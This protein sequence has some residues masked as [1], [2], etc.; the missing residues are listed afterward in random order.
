M[1]VLYTHL[2]G[3]HSALYAGKRYSLQEL[4]R[5][6]QALPQEVKK[7]TQAAIRKPAPDHRWYH[8]PINPAKKLPKSKTTKTPIANTG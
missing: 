6:P 8:M 2:D 3:S 4:Q 5:P 7:T 1:V